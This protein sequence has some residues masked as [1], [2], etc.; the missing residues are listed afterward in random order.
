MAMDW[1]PVPTPP[2]FM[3][4]TEHATLSTLSNFNAIS[5]LG[6]S[7]TICDFTLVPGQTGSGCAVAAAG[8]NWTNAPFT[9]QSAGF[10]VVFD[11]TPSSS[12]AQ[13]D[14]VMALSNSPQNNASDFSGSALLVRFNSFGTID[15][16]NGGVYPSSSYT[17]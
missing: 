3:L 4:R 11:A 15:A 7:S 12:G 5:D 2:K 1:D 9:S 16:R 8:A 13:M 17:Y 14:S 6:A 10:T